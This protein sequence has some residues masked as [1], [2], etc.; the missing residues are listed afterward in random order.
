MRK[1]LEI[2]SETFKIHQENSKLQ[3]NRLTSVKVSRDNFQPAKRYVSATLKKS[4]L[5][6]TS[7]RCS[8]PGC[9]RPPENFHHTDRFAISHSHQSIR[10]L[11]KIHH[12][13]AHNG[14]ILNEQ[15]PTENWQF[16]LTEK[17]DNQ[18]DY[19]YR[20]YRKK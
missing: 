18:I 15:Q 16:E 6:E 2:A 20:K 13:F 14:I 4:S 8:Y 17:L 3:I 10:P 19:L 7:G 11:C 12:E 5:Q 9:N 1:V